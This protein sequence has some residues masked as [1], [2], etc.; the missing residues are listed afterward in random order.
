VT[1]K[2]NSI[3]TVFRLARKTMLILRQNLSWALLYNVVAISLAITAI[4]KP[5][6]A[7]IG[8]SVSSIIVVL[9]S[10]RLRRKA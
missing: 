5:W 1:E 8:M 2:I 7:A 9:N 10:I 6:M 4:V 3:F